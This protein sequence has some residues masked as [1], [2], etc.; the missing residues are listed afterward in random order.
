[1][2]IDPG[3]DS[4]EYA[5]FKEWYHVSKMRL[6]SKEFR[7][8]FNT[9]KGSD[10]VYIYENGSSDPT[11]SGEI[12]YMGAKTHKGENGNTSTY[13]TYTIRYD[14]IEGDMHGRSKWHA[15]FEETFHAVDFLSGSKNMNY[16]KS[17]G[18]TFVGSVNGDRSTEATAWIWAGLHAPFAPKTPAVYDKQTGGNMIFTNSLIQQIKAGASQTQVENALYNGY[19]LNFEIWNNGQ[20]T[21]TGHLPAKA[22][23]QY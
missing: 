14:L 3:G 5:G 10:N 11:A 13:E 15:L 22:T 12:E 18:R 21:N 7:Q 1:M 6:F 19:N 20:K 2:M 8:K 4:V 9:L 17:N 23:K 16:F